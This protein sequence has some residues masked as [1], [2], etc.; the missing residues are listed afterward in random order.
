MNIIFIEPAF[1]ANQREFVRA[2]SAIGANIYGIGERPLEWLDAETRARLTHYQQIESVTNEGALEWATRDAQSRVWIDRMEATVEAHTLPVARVRERCSIPGVSARTTYLCRD[3]VAMKEVLR[4][5][6]IPVAVSGGISSLSEAWDFA[7]AVGYPLII[8][9]RDSAGAAGTYRANNAA[10]LDR[11]AHAAGVADGTPAAIE[12]YIEGHEGIYDTVTVQG[13]VRHDFI[14]H[15][16]PGVLEAMRTRWISPQLI[17]TNAVEADRYAELRDMGRRVIGALGITTAPTHMEWFF[18][19]KGLKFSEI[20]CR[21]PGVGQWDSYCAGNEYDLYREWALAV[22][23]HTSD[24]RPSRRYACGIIALRPEC[25]GH[26]TGYE[27]TETI[28]GKYGN[29]VVGQ[30]FPPPDTPT[31]QV[32]AGYMANAWMRVRH[33]D[34]DTLHAILNEIG[35]TIRVRAR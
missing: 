13:D 1:P 10:E 25:D 18:G 11:A 28:F 19:P 27:G 7:E 26:I 8:K 29:L 5:A 34:H 22:C 31:Q 4:A 23:H 16:Y 33:E 32:E 6:G 24:A 15:Y 21:P 35:E 17:S 3:K 20:G 12:E 30:H 2:L 9:P 14:G